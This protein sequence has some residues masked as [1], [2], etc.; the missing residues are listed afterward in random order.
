MNVAF[1]ERGV[2]IRAGPSG[3]IHGDLAVPTN[4]GGLVVFVHGSGSSR[5]SPRN[6]RVAHALQARGLATL[7]VDLL[8]DDEEAIDRR[9]AE[10]RFDIDLL[11]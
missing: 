10:L 1:R 5:H 7:L 3:T 9:T 8:T 4:S 2:Q 11:A 6:R